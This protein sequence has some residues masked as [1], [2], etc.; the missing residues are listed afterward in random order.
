[1]PV[2]VTAHADECSF[3]FDPIGQNT[4]DKT[5][6]D[7]AKAYLTHGGTCYSNID[8]PG[9]TMAQDQV[10]DRV[11]QAPDPG[12]MRKAELAEE[13]ARFENQ[14]GTALIE[15]GYPTEADPEKINQPLVIGI[16]LTIMLMVTATYAP[17]AAMLVELFP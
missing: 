2:T 17:L 6:C 5:S 10:G 1:S 3:Q 9:R 15:A 13:I 4:C 11:I 7:I 12:T 14:V 8:M 16:I